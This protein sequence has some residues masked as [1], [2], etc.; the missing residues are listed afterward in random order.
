MAAC[1]LE[2]K[3]QGAE[4]IKI[5]I[6]LV[7]CLEVYIGILFPNNQ[8]NDVDKTLFKLHR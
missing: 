2:N 6:N 4:L 5:C 3:G 7:I 1:I 8:L